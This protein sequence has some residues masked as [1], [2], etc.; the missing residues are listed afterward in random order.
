[1]PTNAPSSILLS[2]ARYV[3]DS[4]LIAQCSSQRRQQDGCSQAD[5]TADQ[6]DGKD[7][8]ESFHVSGSLFY[9]ACSS[10]C[11]PAPG[12]ADA[13]HNSRFAATKRMMKP[14]MVP[15]SSRESPDPIAGRSGRPASNRKQDGNDEHPEGMSGQGSRQS[16]RRT[17]VRPRSRCDPAVDSHHLDCPRQPCKGT[18]DQHGTDSCLV[19]ADASVERKPPRLSGHALLVPGLGPPGGYRLR[20]PR[21]PQ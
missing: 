1:M 18:A 4:G 3:E 14:M 13:L 11:H 10:A 20:S 21:S 19:A 2:R 12:A 8:E 15:P 9:R 16:A 17:R 6:F 7:A 5:A